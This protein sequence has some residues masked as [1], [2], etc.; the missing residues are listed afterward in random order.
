MQTNSKSKKV[1]DKLF[2]EDNTKQENKN[3]LNIELDKK[4]TKP[5]F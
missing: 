4:S 1:I 2:K 5:D 3:K